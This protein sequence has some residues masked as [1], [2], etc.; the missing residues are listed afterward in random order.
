[1]MKK[2]RNVTDNSPKNSKILFRESTLIIALIFVLILILAPFYHRF[3]DQSH[4]SYD[5]RLASSVWTAMTEVMAEVQDSSVSD[6]ETG[7]SQ[8]LTGPGAGAG[9]GQTP[10]KIGEFTTDAGAQ[11]EA[12]WAE[13][14]G[15][16]GVRGPK[17][18][19][20]QLQYR[21]GEIFYY[22]DGERNVHVVIRYESGQRY[23]FPDS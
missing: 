13:V 12:F 15:R 11:G 2:N 10:L 19:D 8:V 20:G 4:Q 23:D 1:M 3:L 18:L 7:N 9:D 5:K 16:L 17:D 14:Y 21:D 22:T 6:V